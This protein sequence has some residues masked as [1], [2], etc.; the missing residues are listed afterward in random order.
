MILIQSH[1]LMTRASDR[2][3]WNPIQNRSQP[4]TVY[5]LKNI[6]YGYFWLTSGFIICEFNLWNS[7]IWAF[8][9]Y[10]LFFIHWQIVNFANCPNNIA[11]LMCEHC[12]LSRSSINKVGIKCFFF[13]LCVYEQVLLNY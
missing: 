5:V 9:K 6:A 2:V 4:F 13:N 10:F 7:H 1:S 12:S 3:D 11:I 8:V